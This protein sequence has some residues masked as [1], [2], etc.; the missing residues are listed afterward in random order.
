MVS[1]IKE[2]A[3]GGATIENLTHVIHNCFGGDL[4]FLLDLADSVKT[5]HFGN[6]V[7]IRA[8]VEFSSYCRCSCAYCG[9]N[10]NADLP[11]YRMSFDEI[12][13][14]AREVYSAGYQTLILQSGEDSFFTCDLLCDLIKQIVVACPGMAITLSLGEREVWEYE[15]FYECGGNRYLLKHETSDE[16]LYF[17]LHGVSIDNRLACSRALKEIGYELGSGFMIGLPG[18]TSKTL[19]Q[20]ILLLKELGVDMAGIGPFIASPLTELKGEENG[21]A[22][23]TLKILALTRLVLPKIHLPSTTALNVLGGRNNALFCGANVIMQKATPFAYRDLYEIY[24]G[25]EAPKIPL[26]QQF[27]DLK[28]DLNEMGLEGV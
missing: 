2:I 28:N 20:D 26:K 16:D 27:L 7:Y 15:R 19:A 5:K 25:R 18:Q 24:P 12:L 4:Q 23:L 10:C 13:E 3:G 17:K 14:S 8:I 21:S 6:K 22:E 1:D 11:R 9:L